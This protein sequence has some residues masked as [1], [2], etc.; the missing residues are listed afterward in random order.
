M[1]IMGHLTTIPLEIVAIKVDHIELMLDQVNQMFQ[2]D[3]M[4]SIIENGQTIMMV[5]RED[6]D[7]NMTIITTRPQVLQTQQ[8]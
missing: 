4:G 1:I 8:R 6:I 7:Q 5:N 2:I 3:M